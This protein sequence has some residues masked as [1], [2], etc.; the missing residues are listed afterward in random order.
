M[1]LTETLDIDDEISMAELALPV[2]LED[3]TIVTRANWQRSEN[4]SSSLAHG[5]GKISS[6]PRKPHIRPVHR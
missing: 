1:L 3:G 2:P 4:Q 5:A 6:A